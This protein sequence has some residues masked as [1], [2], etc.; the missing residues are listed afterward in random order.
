MTASRSIITKPCA[1][2]WSAV[3]GT[4]PGRDHLRR[5]VPCQ[6]AA[7]TCAGSRA[8]LLVCDGRG[9]AARSE[10]GAQAAVRVFRE[11]LYQMECLLA[12]CLDDPT[13]T[14]NVVS[15]RWRLLAGSLY[16][17]LAQV[18]LSLVAQRG[19]RSQDYEFTAVAFVGGRCH[20][21]WFCVG[22]SIL[23]VEQAGQLIALGLEEG[24]E[25]ANQTQFIRPVAAPEMRFAS[26]SLPMADLGLVAGF[27]DGTASRFFDLKARRPAAALTQ[28][29]ELLRSGQFRQEDLHEMLT[30]RDWDAATGDDRSLAMLAA[31]PSCERNVSCPPEDAATI[32]Q[33]LILKHVAPIISECASAALETCKGKE[34]SEPPP[35]IS[36]P[37]CTWLTLPRQL[38]IAG[39]LFDLYL[40]CY[41]L[42]LKL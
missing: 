15:A 35:V 36:T 5:G 25:Y 30:D 6:D 26:G 32:A 22:D 33:P 8:G 42:L 31:A 19:G 27:S 41:L 13:A 12:D 3:H 9:S 11:W 2:Q 7:F 1:F 34:P 29:G 14:P 23:A 21:A 16:A 24:G 4:T 37:S 38:L 18:Q 10:L 28:L 17:T 39:A 40:L 20:G